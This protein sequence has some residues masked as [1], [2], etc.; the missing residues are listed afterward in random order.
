MAATCNRRTIN[1]HYDGDDDDADN[2]D[3]RALMTRSLSGGF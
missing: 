1:L 2:D 3:F